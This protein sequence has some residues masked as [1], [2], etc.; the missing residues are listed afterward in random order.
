[1]AEQFEALPLLKETQVAHHLNV[2]VSTLR[3]WRWA[4]IGP[5]YVKIGAAVRYIPDVMRRYIDEQSVETGTTIRPHSRT[6]SLQH[7]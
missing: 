2:K 5:P 6:K 4:G 7:G 3:R 1:M